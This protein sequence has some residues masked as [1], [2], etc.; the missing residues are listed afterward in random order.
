M[1]DSQKPMVFMDAATA[2]ANAKITPTDAPNSGPSEREIIKYTPPTR[3]SPLVLMADKDNVVITQT[4][5]EIPMMARDCRI[6]D[7]ATTQDK[8]RNNITPQILSRQGIMTPTIHPSLMVFDVIPLLSAC[9][10]SLSSCSG[11]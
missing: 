6:P 1:S 7:S 10:S 8:R 4:T 2:L 9:S 3:T 11:S 5:A